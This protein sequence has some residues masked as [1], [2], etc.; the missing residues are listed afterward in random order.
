MK[1]DFRF[2]SFKRKFNTIPF[3]HSLMIGC[4]KRNRRNYLKRLSN[5]GIK[6]SRLKF[7]TKLALIGLKQPGTAL[8]IRRYSDTLSLTRLSYA[9][10]VCMFRSNECVI[11]VSVKMLKTN[12]LTSSMQMTKKNSGLEFFFCLLCWHKGMHVL[13]IM[14]HVTCKSYV[15]A[16]QAL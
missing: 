7:N 9:N 1:S 14:S 13:L 4:P 15:K 11:N 16:N 3:G 6:K 12:L 10:D 5:K 8:S 2:G